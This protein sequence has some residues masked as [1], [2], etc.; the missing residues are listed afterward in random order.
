[1]PVTSFFAS[2][3]ASSE[4]VVSVVCFLDELDCSAGPSPVAEEDETD[5]FSGSSL[6][7]SSADALEDG[8]EG[9]SLGAELEESSPQAARPNARQAADKRAVLFK[10]IEMFIPHLMRIF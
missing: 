8:F 10:N 7:S 4:L 3:K 1:M 9:L 6:P 5:G 2:F